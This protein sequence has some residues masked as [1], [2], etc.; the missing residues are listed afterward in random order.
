MEAKGLVG[1]ALFSVALGLGASRAEAA[2]ISVGTPSA[3]GSDVLIYP[4]EISDGLDVLSW[5][6][7][8]AYDANVVNIDT[9]CDP[10]AGDQYCDLFTG[11]VTPGE[12]FAAGDPLAAEAPG[13]RFRT[14][15]IVARQFQPGG[16]AGP[17]DRAGLAAASFEFPVSWRGAA[18][19]CMF[20][21]LGGRGGWG[22]PSLH[23]LGTL[24]AIDQ[25]LPDGHPFDLSSLDPA[26]PQFWT[27]TDAPLGVGQ[28]VGTVKFTMVKRI[29]G[30]QGGTDRRIAN[31]HAWC[32][33]GGNDPGQP[34][35]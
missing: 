35:F 8:L 15:L 29:P 25:Q 27:S 24:A 13:S 26:G 12:F 22:L 17:R 31:S 7:D 14:P 28:G 5:Q 23:E 33:R 18:E 30:L 9:T 32:V 1:L 21:D 20:E 19:T 11:P 3:D 6:F 4:V 2:T 34:S 10:F 16:G